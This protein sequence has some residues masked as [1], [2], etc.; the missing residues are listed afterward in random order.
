MAFATSPFSTTAFS[1]ESSS[2]F[3]DVTGISSSTA[4]NN[5]GISGTIGVD[6]VVTGI[7]LSITNSFAFTD[8]L[9]AFGESPF[10]S[11]SL[12][13][14]SPV[15]IVVSANAD[16]SVSG[17]S[18]ASAVGEEVPEGDATQ[19]VSGIALSSNVGSVN[20]F[21]LIEVAVTGIS[22][23][24][25]IGNE[26]AR[27]NADVPVTGISLTSA[28]GNEDTDADADVSVTGIS[29]TSAIGNESITGDA[30]ISLSGIQLST[31]VG[32]VNHNSTYTVTGSQLTTA[33][34]EVLTD[35]ASAETT[36]VSASMSIGQVIVS[37]WSEVDPGVSNVWTEVDLAA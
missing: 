2:I 14:I 37:G 11:E 8:T 21:S 30:N 31:A 34:G 10:A 25:A 13:T 7:P 16:V 19:V 23:A 4:I 36:G 22:L 29:L 3:V 9:S 27:A 18:L 17:I 24:S 20:A 1:Q 33:V 6:A 32:S 12:S 35:D 15:N 28:L 26:T 5:V